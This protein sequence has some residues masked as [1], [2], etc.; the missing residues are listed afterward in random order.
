MS[1]SSSNLFLVLFFSRTWLLQCARLAAEAQRVTPRVASSLY[2]CYSN[3]RSVL[4]LS[5]FDGLIFLGIH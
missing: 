2:L 5:E 3:R 1:T 4:A